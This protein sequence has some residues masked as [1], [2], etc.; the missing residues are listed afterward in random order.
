MIHM[1][2]VILLGVFFI[3]PACA[4]SENRFRRP[5]GPG[6]AGDFRDNPVYTLGDNIDL[7]WETDLKNIDLILWQQQPPANMKG[8]YAKLAI[9]ST[10]KSLVWTVGYAGFPP[11]L[12]P[13]MSPVYFLQLFKTGQTGS[14]AT[15]H[16]FNI[17]RTDRTSTSSTRPSASLKTTLSSSTPAL[18]LG[19]A[20]A[21]STSTPSVSTAAAAADDED[22]LSSSAVAGVAVG[23]T[24]GA[25]GL[26]GFLAWLIRRHLKR[27]REMAVHTQGDILVYAERQLHEK[28]A[29]AAAEWKLELPAQS[30]E[31]FELE[32][33]EPRHEM[34]AEPVVGMENGSVGLGSAGQSR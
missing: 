19:S 20:T 28:D 3:F 27:R 16:Y 15:S 29:A 24:L 30:R 23:A 4:R 6:P 8:P 31:R 2:A 17:T 22:Q 14:S 10:I 21:T 18:A 11:T 34:P 12:D 25:L 7:Q 13:D 26:I 9:N 1:L 5:P 32:A 33:C